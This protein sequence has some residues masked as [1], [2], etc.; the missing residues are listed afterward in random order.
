VRKPVFFLL[1]FFTSAGLLW[2]AVGKEGASFLDIPVGAEPAALGS[3]YTALAENAYASVW[4]P[5]GLASVDVPEIAG[6]H[7]SYLESVNYE[8]LSAAIPLHAGAHPKGLGIS[9]QA[10]GSGTID[11]RDETGNLT[12]SFTSTFAAYSF[13]YGQALTQQTSIGGALKIIREKISDASASAYAI[14]LGW[15]YR[16]QRKWT[17]GAAISNLGTS[18]KLVGQSDPLPL[19]ARFGTAWRFN[20]DFQ[21]SDDIIYRQNGPI[22]NGLGFE[23]SPSD[24]Y[25][26]RAGYNTSHTK[27]LGAIAGFTAGAALRFLGQE[28]AY[29]WVPFGDLGNTHYFSLLIRFSLEPRLDRSQ[30]DQTTPRLHKRKRD[31]DDD[32]SFPSESPATGY[33]DYGNVYDILTDD[34]RKSL[35]KTEQQQKKDS[36]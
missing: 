29:A 32:H 19:Q 5:A 7:L 35:K 28:F 36:E 31:D 3:A 14:D 16:P 20:S 9:V 33:H 11:Q 27:E 18:I 23:W 4:N 21:L 10:L 34:E 24:Y 25:A 22:A 8:H 30:P 26:L 2:A 12:G 6:M 15:L 1:Y 17:L 13:S